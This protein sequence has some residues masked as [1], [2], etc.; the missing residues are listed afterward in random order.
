MTAATINRA[1]KSSNNLITAAKAK[2]DSFAYAL[3]KFFYNLVS[4]GHAK[5][6]EQAREERRGKEI[7]SVVFNILKKLPED[8]NKLNSPGYIGKILYTNLKKNYEIVLEGDELCIYT[9]KESVLSLGWQNDFVRDVGSRI[10]LKKIGNIDDFDDFKSLLSQVVEVNYKKSLDK[11]KGV[12][13]QFLDYVRTMVDVHILNNC[14][15]SHKNQINNDY[16]RS[17]LFMINIGNKV[18]PIK[19]YVCENSFTV[20]HKLNLPDNQKNIFPLLI[21]Q[22]YSS[23]ISMPFSA[24]LINNSFEPRKLNNNSIFVYDFVNNNS[25]DETEVDIKY[26]YLFSYDSDPIIIKAKIF[27]KNGDVNKIV[28]AKYESELIAINKIEI[29]DTQISLGSFR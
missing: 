4:F 8:Y 5:S 24:A 13:N 14:S 10:I 6:M 23:L 1:F 3:K 22:V 19:D 2:D 15:S 27:F 21:N 25:E 28:E 11:L 7:V 17:S 9:G 26:T 18:K 20:S 12:E 16:N 29:I